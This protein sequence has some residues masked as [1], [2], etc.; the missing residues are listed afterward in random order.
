MSCVHVSMWLWTLMKL[1]HHQTLKKNVC[2]KIT[3]TLSILLQFNFYFYFFLFRL[4]SFR[5]QCRLDCFP[6][7]ILIVHLLSK[8]ETVKWKLLKLLIDGP[9]SIFFFFYY[10]DLSIIYQ[11]GSIKSTI[12][13]C[14]SKIFTNLPFEK[15][16]L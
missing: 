4:F 13:N 15:K 12:I 16:E 9:T 1:C 14:E 5:F 7:S 11:V 2:T 6:F 3:P 8:A 10:H